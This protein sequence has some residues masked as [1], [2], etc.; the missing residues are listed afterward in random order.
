VL[1]R[2]GLP[3][4]YLLLG[5]YVIALSI[6]ALLLDKMILIL[7]IFGVAAIL[8]YAARK[9]RTAILIVLVAALFSSAYI[10]TTDF[11]FNHVLE[12]HQQERVDVLLGKKIEAKGAGYN[13]RQ[14][15]IAI[16]S[17]GLTGKGFLQG[18]LTKYN[19]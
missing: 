13:V 17:G 12:K 6:L 2:F 7:V 15:E 9:N 1:F 8:L 18:T 11:V 5:V 4:Y 19:F 3:G 14:S 10:F 16:G